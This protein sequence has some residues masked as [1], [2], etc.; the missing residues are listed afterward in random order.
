MF[1]RCGH[2]TRAVI[3]TAL[4]EARDL[5]HHWLG[6]EHVL[7]ALTV[8]RDRLPQV[9]EQLLPTAGQVRRALDAA[10]ELGPSS[11][12]AELLGTLGIDLDEVRAAVRATFGSDAVDRFAQRRVHQPWQPWRRPDRACA[13]LLAG[14]QNVA[15]RLEQAFAHAAQTAS[16]VD[17][18]L[19]EP[20]ALLQGVLEVEDALATRLLDDLGIARSDLHAAAQ[21][22]AS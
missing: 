5:G 11:P 12:D 17:N 10:V 19:I 4:A 13:S 22:A 3:D 14:T 18:R 7:I 6:T 9:V 15:P 2:E 21:P 8:H 1:D 16:D 20:V